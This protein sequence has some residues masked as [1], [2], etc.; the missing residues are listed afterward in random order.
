MVKLKE[1]AVMERNSR[2]GGDNSDNEEP[3]VSGGR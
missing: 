2:D 3:A 1:T